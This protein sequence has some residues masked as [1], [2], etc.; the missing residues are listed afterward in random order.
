M[1]VR[2]YFP[3]ELNCYLSGECS[4][5]K[6]APSYDS[7]DSCN[8]KKETRLELP[9][10]FFPQSLCVYIICSVCIVHVRNIVEFLKVGRKIGEKGEIGGGAASHV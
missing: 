3:P 4:A 5:T 2:R 6:G 1:R 10:F 9:F 8:K 7:E